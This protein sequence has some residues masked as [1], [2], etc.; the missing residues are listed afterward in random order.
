MICN[1]VRVKRLGRIKVIMRAATKTEPKMAK[2]SIGMPMAQCMKVTGSRIKFRD[3]E[4]IHGQIIR[5]FKVSG[6]IIICMDKVCSSGQ[7]AENMKVNTKTT[8][9]M[10]LE[11]ILGPMG[12]NMPANGKMANSMVKEFIRIFRV[13]KGQAFGKMENV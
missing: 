11:Y 13:L 7:T 10:G 6:L 2:G 5:L 8:K 12:D 1:M 4:L 9:S 3:M